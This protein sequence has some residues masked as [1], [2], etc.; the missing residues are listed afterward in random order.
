M[1][2]KLVY[3]LIIFGLVSSVSNI[4]MAAPGY[5]YHIGSTADATKSFDDYYNIYGAA[6]NPYLDTFNFILKKGKLNSTDSYGFVCQHLL[7]SVRSCNH[8]V[9]VITYKAENMHTEVAVK[10][11]GSG[12]LDDGGTFVLVNSDGFL[13]VVDYA[14]VGGGYGPNTNT[15]GMYRSSPTV[16]YDFQYDG[17]YHKDTTM[18]YTLWAIHDS[19]PPKSIA[20]NWFGLANYDH[21]ITAVEKI[22]LSGSPRLFFFL[23]DGRYI[24]YSLDRD[25]V[26]NRA[27]FPDNELIEL[28][29]SPIARNEVVINSS[30]TAKPSIVASV[31]A[32]GV[33]NSNYIF[34]SDGTYSRFHLDSSKNI[35]I[36]SGYPLPVTKS[37]WPGLEDYS[38]KIVAATSILNSSNNIF[39][40]FL[41]DGT[42]VTFDFNDNKVLTEEPLK[43]TKTWPFM[44]SYSDIPIVAADTVN[45]SVVFY[46]SNGMAID[47]NGIVSNNR[48]DLTAVDSY[49]AHDAEGDSSTIF[50]TNNQNTPSDFSPSLSKDASTYHSTIIHSTDPQSDDNKE[51]HLNH[52]CNANNSYSLECSN[53]NLDIGELRFYYSSDKD[54]LTRLDGRYLLISYTMNGD[55]KTYTGFYIPTDYQSIKNNIATYIGYTNIINPA[56]R[57]VFVNSLKINDLPAS[58]YDLAYYLPDLMLS[59]GKGDLQTTDDLPVRWDTKNQQQL[60]VWDE[61]PLG[62]H[63]I[64][65]AQDWYAPHMHYSCDAFKLYDHNTSED[66]TM[67]KYCLRVDMPRSDL[68]K[69]YENAPSL[70]SGRALKFFTAP[71]YTRYKEDGG[72]LEKDYSTVSNWGIDA[73]HAMEISG[74][75]RYYNKIV[76]FF[77]N[78]GTYSR[79]LE[80]T[81]RMDRDKNGNIIYRSTSSNWDMDPGYAKNISGV[82]NNE[83]NMED[84]TYF[85]YNDGTYSRYL[86][87]T[88]R[89]DRDKNG[90]IIYSSTS[91]NW[92]MD[93]T[94]AKNISGIV[95][96]EYNMKNNTYFFYNNG[97]YSRYD[98]TSDKMG[99]YRQVSSNWDMDSAHAKS[100]SG[101]VNNLQ[102]SPN[103]TY[104]F[105]K[106]SDVA[107]GIVYDEELYSN[108]NQSCHELDI[109]SCKV[110]LFIRS[111]KMIDDSVDTIAFPILNPYP[112]SFDHYYKPDGAF[113]YSDEDFYSQ[114]G[115]NVNMDSWED[116]KPP[117]FPDNHCPSVVPVSLQYS[118]RPGGCFTVTLTKDNFQKI[119]SALISLNELIYNPDGGSEKFPMEL[120]EYSK[121]GFGEYTE[122]GT[123]DYVYDYQVVGSGIKLYLADYHESDNLNHTEFKDRYQHPDDKYQYVLTQGRTKFCTQYNSLLCSYL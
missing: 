41:N 72:Y 80:E 71:K 25:V 22:A 3:K 1:N 94:Y 92:D 44:A 47:Q 100:I 91:S 63:S 78:D 37:T 88:G 74:I 104:F 6:Y 55:P 79:Y 90:N 57:E 46:L 117:H 101:I 4:S 62:I 33:A 28:R 30:L 105:F 11:D 70:L 69:Y 16:V 15:V 97:Q 113:L 38:K 87:A 24:K 123:F 66:N 93:P 10:G 84:K 61:N 85:F 60:R 5:R 108:G 48:Q 2:K 96:N 35:V 58:Y 26:T 17:S 65:S 112:Q 31:T 118:I 102:D 89:M 73:S 86:K 12:G 111:D 36:D 95:N 122:S 110:A 32:Y 114:A 23:S 42:Y 75:V 18:P 52:Y 51:P 19:N 49:M 29:S 9:G 98:E 83:Y 119:K 106:S 56:G 45:G 40:F 67:P 120:V 103:R 39:Y 8:V 76:Y 68:G 121:Q 82:I 21:S 14:T 109:N 54:S 13:N 115:K 64:I 107:T 99:P 53:L 20:D 34:F 77:Y 81:G 43:I 27:T 50:F 116:D 59:N 7:G